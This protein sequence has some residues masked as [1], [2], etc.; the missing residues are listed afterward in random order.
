MGF[1]LGVSLG[2]TRGPV[3]TGGNGKVLRN[4]Q[5]ITKRVQRRSVQ[6]GFPF[7]FLRKVLMFLSTFNMLGITGHVQ[8]RSVQN[9]F[10][11]GFH[12]GFCQTML[13]DHPG[14]H[15]ACSKEV[16]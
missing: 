7:G 5:G 11:I 16:C 13:R 6:N 9:G 12:I 10:R 2:F 15:Q 8:G 3:T 14:Y 4:H 1:T